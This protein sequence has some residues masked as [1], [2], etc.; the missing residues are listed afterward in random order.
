MRFVAY[1]LENFGV[2]ITMDISKAI[3]EAAK[4]TANATP[5]NFSADDLK[6]LRM[7]PML[8][9]MYVAMSSPSGLIGMAKEAGA[10]TQSLMEAG[11]VASAGSLIGT[12][13]AAGPQQGDQESMLNALK[14]AKNPDELKANLLST[15]KGAVSILQK[16][17]GDA[18]SYSNL[19]MSIATKV[20]EA[21]K[22]GGF[23]GVGGTLVSD[24]EKKALS[25]IAGAL[26][27]KQ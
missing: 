12:L 9:G 25:E 19:L 13:F 24:D 11:K 26:G 14:S 16:N 3:Q 5:T 10:T 15:F 18:S 27:M 8:V 2:R 20:A 1:F 17:S 7:A 23:L 21:A 6:T 4:T 22:E